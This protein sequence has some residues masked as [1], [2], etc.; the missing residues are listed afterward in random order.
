MCYLSQFAD[1]IEEDFF[2]IAD[3]QRQKQLIVYSLD[4][5]NYI[6]GNFVVIPVP[7]NGLVL[8]DS[9][10]YADFFKVIDARFDDQDDRYENDDMVT[11]KDPHSGMIDTDGERI[12]PKKVKVD[13]KSATYK[14]VKIANSVKELQDAGI[15]KT[16]V[17]KLESHTGSFILCELIEQKNEKKNAAGLTFM[18][19][20]LDS[21]MSTKYPPIVFE[22]DLIDATCLE[23]PTKLFSG[24]KMTMDSITKCVVYNVNSD[25]PHELMGLYNHKQTIKSCRMTFPNFNY[26]PT[27]TITK[28]IFRDYDTNKNMKALMRQIPAIFDDAL[29]AEENYNN[30]LNSIN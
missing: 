29:S 18:R 24:A 10:L 13:K 9:T 15:S 12:G 2:V 22:H 7:S 26:E 25:I 28:N 6:N 30:L 14:S 19:R 8:H 11:F 3:R 5:Q 23:V 21:G 17:E 16:C 4:I 20:L 1:I 27:L